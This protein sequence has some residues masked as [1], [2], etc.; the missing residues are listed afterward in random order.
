MA[1]PTLRNCVHACGAAVA[2][3]LGRAGDLI[4]VHAIASISIT[5]QA[6]A[7]GKVFGNPAQ[8]A[9]MNSLASQASVQQGK[10]AGR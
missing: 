5:I 8:K 3:C 10:I 2:I 7:I 4:Q 6:G 9:L 1:R